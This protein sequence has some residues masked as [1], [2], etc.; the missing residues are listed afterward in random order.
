MSC[1]KP[2]LGK[3]NHI[4]FEQIDQ[5][6][7][8]ILCD[9]GISAALDRLFTIPGHRILAEFT[10]SLSSFLLI[11]SKTHLLTEKL[12]AHLP[13]WFMGASICATLEVVNN[14]ILGGSEKL[15]IV[16]ADS[17]EN[18]TPAFSQIPSIDNLLPFLYAAA[19]FVHQKRS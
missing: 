7:L 12:G 14:P 9:R 17:G 16:W 1:W 2:F 11:L 6:P 15:S 8:L 4:R 5:E 10:L 13:I 3:P 18:Q 19:D